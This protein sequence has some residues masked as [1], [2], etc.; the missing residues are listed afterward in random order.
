MEDMGQGCIIMCW[1]LDIERF[2]DE[3]QTELD[4]PGPYVMGLIF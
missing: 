2:A 4:A 3:L 1:P